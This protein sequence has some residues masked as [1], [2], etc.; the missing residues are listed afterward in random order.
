MAVLTAGPLSSHQIRDTFQKLISQQLQL[1]TSCGSH[2]TKKNCLLQRAE[3]EGTGR[4]S[5]TQ[6]SGR[7]RK[8][9]MVHENRVCKRGG[10]GGRG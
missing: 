1:L 7:A 6:E 9:L 8:L 2:E 3:G 10:V 4:R 5:K